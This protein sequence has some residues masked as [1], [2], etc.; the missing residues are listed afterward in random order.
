MA[1]VLEVTIE[2]PNVGQGDVVDGAADD[3]DGGAEDGIGGADSEGGK[4][5]EEGRLCHSLCR[6][7]H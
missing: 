4:G 2:K 5:N 3:V 1:P 7:H 6:H